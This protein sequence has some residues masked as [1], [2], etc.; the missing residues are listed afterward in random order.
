LA[1]GDWVETVADDADAMVLG[2]GTDHS[3]EE[4]FDRGVGLSSHPSAE[5]RPGPRVQGPAAPPGYCSVARGG[6]AMEDRK[7]VLM[8]RAQAL[9]EVFLPLLERSYQAWLAQGR[10]YVLCEYDGG[11]PPTRVFAHPDDLWTAEKEAEVDLT[12]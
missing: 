10:T 1:D 6:L 4:D 7:C 3:W 2:D 8:S 9:E 12:L 5:G 11:A